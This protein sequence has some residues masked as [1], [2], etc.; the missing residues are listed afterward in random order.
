MQ[1]AVRSSVTA[2]VALL[3][4]GVIAASPIAPPVPAL[5][6][7]A[8]HFDASLAAAV[9]PIDSYREVFEAARTNLQAL[10][11]AADPGEVLKQIVANQTASLSA[12]GT[13]LGD[14]GNGL[15][16][17]LTKTSPDL[18]KTVLTSLA[19]G[20]VEAATNALLTVPVA[21][22]LPL[23]NLLPAVEQFVTQP[24][25]NLINVA[26]VFR[27]P[28]QDGLYVVGLLGPVISG[29][30]AAG[31]ATQNVI[32][33][34]R[35]GDPRQVVNAILTGP[36]TILDGVLNGG[37]GPDLGPL[38][39][40]GLSVLAGGLFSAS[41]ISIGPDGGIILNAA[42][43][44]S[45]L[46]TLAHQ[47]AAALKPAAITTAAAVKTKELPAASA[48]AETTV[49][50]DKPATEKPKTDPSAP[51]DTKAPTDAKASAKPLQHKPSV[52]TTT[53]DGND[54]KSGT[55]GPKHQ[56]KAGGRGHS[57]R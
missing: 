16:T 44:I 13:A 29:L 7:P 40:P 23:I 17:A 54:G 50:T 51:T 25:Q 9:S 22:G 10:V 31:A 32:D 39:S 21:V 46:Q 20:N 55:A 15:F 5:H 26:G 35:T 6:L 30:G 2:G 18:V 53:K 42:G 11:D 49:T 43:P 19:A 8:L 36:A 24:V 56:H 33:A 45:T 12:L 34:V 57:G 1:R 4:A 47:I 41:G 28:L 37:F 14:A 27:D 48:T 38:V 3:G 52:S